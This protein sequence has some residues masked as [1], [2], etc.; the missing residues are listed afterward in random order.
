[1][2][3]VS[4]IADGQVAP[5]DGVGIAHGRRPETPYDIDLEQDSRIEVFDLGCRRRT[6][7]E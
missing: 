2:Q 7:D 3:V 1:M 6:P 4:T 5:G